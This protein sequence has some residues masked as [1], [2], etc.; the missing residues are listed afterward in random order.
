M[1]R[2]KDFIIELSGTYLTN[3]N[4]L[5]KDSER[6]EEE[7]KSIDINK[8]ST[9]I[10]VVTHGGFIMEF[11]NVVRN[12]QGMAP[13]YNNSSKNTSITIVKFEKGKDGKLAASVLLENDNSHLNEQVAKKEE[14]KVLGER[15]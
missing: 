14:K 10:L 7:K 1:N 11:M 9:R 8:E 6:N 3:E 15:G 13:I 12:L 5:N 4:E 2:A